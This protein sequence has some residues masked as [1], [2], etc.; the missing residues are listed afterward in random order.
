[1]GQSGEK[2][3]AAYKRLEKWLKST[4]QKERLLKKQRAMAKAREEEEEEERKK[5]EQSQLVMTIY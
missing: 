2:A 3:V 4:E 1:M 5:M